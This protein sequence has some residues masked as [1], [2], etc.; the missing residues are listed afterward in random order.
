MVAKRVFIIRVSIDSA[1][2]HLT[3]KDSFLLSLLT[4]GA[5]SNYHDPILSPHL[6]RAKYVE[7]QGTVIKYGV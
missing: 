1:A 3:I 2:V 7:K 4:A 5:H 6:R